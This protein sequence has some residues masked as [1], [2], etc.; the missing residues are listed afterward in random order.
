MGVGDE[1]QNPESFNLLEK[2]GTGLPSFAKSNCGDNF[3]YEVCFENIT[4]Q[5]GECLC[6]SWEK[7]NI[8]NLEFPM[9]T[10]QQTENIIITS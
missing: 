3:R 8:E 4:Q 2:G 1:T 6:Q 5:G 10:F 7:M 9:K